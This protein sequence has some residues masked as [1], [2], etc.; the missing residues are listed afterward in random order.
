MV[1][2]CTGSHNLCFEKNL[3][4]SSQ[5]FIRKLSLYSH[6]ITINCKG[7][8]KKYCGYSIAGDVLVRKATLLISNSGEAEALNP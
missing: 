6:K 4:K 5:F 3:R 1:L 7:L 2:T 8:L